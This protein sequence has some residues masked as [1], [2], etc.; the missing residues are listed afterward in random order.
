MR[1]VQFVQGNRGRWEQF[2]TELRQESGGDVSRLADLYVGITDDL[3]YARAQY[4]WSLTTQYLNDLAAAA[5]RRLYVNKRGGMAAFK[6]FWRE[7]VPMSFIECRPYLL[8]SLAVF[9]VTYIMAYV[10]TIRDDSLVRGI[11]SDHYVEQ[12]IANIRSGNPMGVYKQMNG[13]DMFAMIFINNQTVMAISVLYG[14]ATIVLPTY[15]CIKHGFMVGAFHALFVRN[16]AGLDFLLGVYIHGA[17]ELSVIVVACAAGMQLGNSLFVPGSYP[18]LESFVRA[19]RSSVRILAGMTPFV[20]VA[21][22]LESFVTRHS[23]MPMPLA[24]GIILS[25]LAATWWYIWILPQQL[26]KKEM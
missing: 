25:T 8:S 16:G 10:V 9:I 12:T 20:F 23:D 5:H 14:L 26:M 2:E 15:Y 7:S 1:E 11:L 13:T 17:V 21:A 3:A 18:R 22:L 4:P 24:I 19:S 6:T